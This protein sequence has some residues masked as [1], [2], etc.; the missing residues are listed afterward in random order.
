MKYRVFS[1]VNWVNVLDLTNNSLEC[2]GDKPRDKAN[3]NVNILIDILYLFSKNAFELITLLASYTH[4][5][6]KRA[7]RYLPLEWK[8]FSIYY[9]V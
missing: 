8:K 6:C 3:L 5:R 9:F 7:M 2:F 1:K 4:K